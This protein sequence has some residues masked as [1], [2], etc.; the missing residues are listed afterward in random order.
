M[1]SSPARTQMRHP[2]EG[3]VSLGREA[4][5]RVLGAVASRPFYRRAATG[6]DGRLGQLVRREMD[7]RPEACSR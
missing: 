5:T 2:A 7:A 6:V 3:E 1:A 4:A